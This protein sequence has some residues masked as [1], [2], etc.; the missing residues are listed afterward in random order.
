M[1]LALT[2]VTT[3]ALAS[4]ACAQQ[5]GQ[6][7]P[8]GAVAEGLVRLDAAIHGGKVHETEAHLVEVVLGP[9]WVR[10]YLLDKRGAKE[11]ELPSTSLEGVAGSV[12]LR[13]QRVTNGVSNRQ[14]KTARLQRIPA[15]QEKGRLRDVLE[16]E[17]TIGNTDPGTYEVEVTLTGVPGEPDGRIRCTVTWSD[18]APADTMA[19]YTCGPC[20]V[21]QVDPGP[22]RGCRSPLHRTLP[23]HGGPGEGPG[24]ASGPPSPG[25]GPR[26]GPGPGP[27]PRP[28]PSP[29]PGPRPGPR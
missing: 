23:G 26:P 28:G 20:D 3:L 4:H 14:A 5:G 29:G 9:T 6:Q 18:A 2:V 19:T 25:P 15:N 16:G 22:C 13:V 24:P 21:A 1:R 12:A 8:R 27:G 10:V 7:D 11:G 17:H